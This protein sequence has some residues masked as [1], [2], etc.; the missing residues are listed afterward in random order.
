MSVLA[1]AANGNLTAAATW[2][3]IDSTSFSRSQSASTALTTSYVESSSFTPGAI[4]I[5][6]IAVYIST[7]AASP[8]GTMSVRLAQGGVTVTGTEV[9][10]NVSDVPT[11]SNSSSTTIPD[12]TG[13][14][15]WFFLKFAAPVTLIAATAYTLSAKTSSG[16]QVNLNSTATSNWS[17]YLRTTTTQAPAAGD[18]MIIVGEWT[19]AATVTNRTVTM[20]STALTDYGSAS[21]SQVS[22]ALAIGKGGTLSYG[23]AGTTDYKLQLSGWLVMY[24][25]G[26]FNMG[27]SGAEIPRGSTAQIVFDCANAGDFGTIGRNGST[28]NTAGLSRTLNKNITWTRLTSDVSAAGTTGNVAA[29]TGWLNG[30]SLAFAPTNRPTSLSGTTQAEKK[31]LTADATSTSITFAAVANAHSGT[32]PTQGEVMLLT[33]NVKWTATTSSNQTFIT[34][35]AGAVM[36]TSWTEYDFLGLNSTA[37][38]AVIETFTNNA[39]GGNTIIDSCSFHDTGRDG[40]YFVG[41]SGGGKGT[42]NNCTFYNTP[43]TFIKNEATTEI[44]AYTNNCGTFHGGNGGFRLNDVGGT[45]TGNVVSGGIN[46]T[47]DG[48]ML[49]ETT[50]ATIGTFKDNMSHSEA[51]SCISLPGLYQGTI[52]NHTGYY[53]AWSGGTGGFNFGNVNLG[54]ASVGGFTVKGCNF[55]GNAV[56]NY[57]FQGNDVFYQIPVTFDNCTGNSTTGNA[58]TTNVQFDQKTHIIENFYFYSCDFDTAS[59]VKNACTNDFTWGGPGTVSGVI[60]ENCKFGA[61]NILT[62]NANWNT[63]GQFGM[64]RLQQTDGTHRRYKK[65]GLILS[66]SGTVHSSNL[67]EELQPNNASNKLTSASMFVPCTDG[68]TKNVSVWLRKNSS[69]AGAAPRVINKRQ[70]SMGVNADTVVATFSAAADTWQQQSFTTPAA[71]E[72]GMFEFYV[73]CDGTAGSVFVDD[74]AVA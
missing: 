6:G 39:S 7:R 58:T 27:S 73:D 65:Y 9:T 53:G 24:N 32:S 72:D 20:D 50:G 33:R 29:D 43:F 67:S 70:D 21:T 60:A 47:N 16:S 11:C 31:S 36:N 5:D 71:L 44:A 52:E 15:G 19:A 8:S 74:W 49:T 17:R 12:G 46:G 34:L 48:F 62:G 10:V 61:T 2:G 45:V 68:Q 41:S 63:L 4:T 18:D 35:A 26:T 66:N 1:A 37:K 22:P 69:Y 30:D 23:T 54:P 59:G 38:F 51:G 42:V 57:W 28:I 56:C 25:G 64:Q 13:E 55:F 40:I 3:L 14:G